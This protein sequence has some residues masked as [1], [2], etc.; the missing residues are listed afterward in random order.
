MSTLDEQTAIITGVGRAGQVG[1][2]VAL[3]F[4]ERGWRV[5]LLGRDRENVTARSEE[6]RSAGHD[7]SPV[8]CDLTD[9][10]ALATVAAELASGLSN[11]VGALVNVAGGFATSGPV[12]DSE[13]TVMRQQLTLNLMTAYLATRAFLPLVR[14]GRGGI[15]YF[16]SIAAL[17][18]RAAPDLLAYAVAKS[19]V[20]TLMRTVAVEEA[21]RGVRANAVAPNTIRTADNVAATGPDARYV[22]LATV[23]DAVLWLATQRGVTG[24]VVR[25][26]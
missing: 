19:G 6:L 9:A 17:P 5:V 16:A 23:T 4:A 1:A 22:E 18:E 3:A 15:V 20:L 12:G 8:I 11:G 10:A 25:L 14:A 13:P 26:G 2:A 24:Q 7:S 21:A